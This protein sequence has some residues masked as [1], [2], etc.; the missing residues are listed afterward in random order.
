MAKSGVSWKCRLPAE[1]CPATPGRKPCLP[2][3]SCR[4]RR[5]LRDPRRGHADVLD[6]Q[7]AAERAQAPDEPEQAL[8][9]APGASR[10]PRASR[11]NA[12]GRISSW[13]GEDLHRGRARA[14]RARHRPRRRT[15]RSARPTRTAARAMPRACRAC[16][17]P[18]RSAPARPSARSRARRPRRAPGTAAAARVDVGEVRPARASCGAGSGRVRM[19]AS[20]MKASVP[21]EPTTRR[22]KIS[23]GVSASRKRAQPVAGD[24]L[25]LVLAPHARGELLVGQQLARISS[26]PAASSGSAAAKRSSASAAAVSMTVPEAS[27]SVID[28]TVE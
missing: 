11:V 15:R 13:R 12:S 17:T 6:D 3:S 8:A 26:S 2:S 21:S 16:S 1:A 4:S 20:A 25:D 10:S 22:R 27:T 7:R 23:S 14:H 9:H 5:A 18:P 28:S 19:T 24:V